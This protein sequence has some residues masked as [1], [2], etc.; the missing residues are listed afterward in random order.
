MSDRAILF[1]DGN[2]WYHSLENSGIA[3]NLSYKAISE[4]LTRPRQ[5]VGTRYYIGKLAPNAPDY[6]QQKRFT[7]GL[8]QEDKRITVH[9]GRI[10][11]RERRNPLVDPLLHL[12]GAWDEKL[13][14][15]FRTELVKLIDKYRW[16]SQYKEKAVD[17]MLAVDMVTM[18]HDDQYDAAYLLSADGDFTPAVEFVQRTGKMV[19]AASP[20]QCAALAQALGY[21]DSSGEEK[22]RYIRLKPEWFGDC[23]I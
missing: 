15:E 22:S 7:D 14:R 1:I 6:K 4:K 3:Q 13:D 2:N 17:V 8:R 11:K 12:I 5:W 18:A 20:A 19:Y 16:I 23:T 21:I 10:E 9:F